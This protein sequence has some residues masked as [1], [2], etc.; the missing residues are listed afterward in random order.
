MP[1]IGAHV[2]GGLKSG[3]ARA[4]E[5]RAEALQIFVGSPQT[6]RPANP[7]AAEVEAFRA[8]VAAADCGPVFVHGIYLINMAAER[9]DVYEKSV[10]ALI[11]QV[12]WAGQVGADGLIFHPG[13]A[14]KA[15]YEEAL[16]R[17]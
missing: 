2:V 9:P 14:G 7:P 16:D 8:D 15:P 6:W 3:V 13:S 1:R 11:S 10:N 12:T 5:I 17:I 4:R